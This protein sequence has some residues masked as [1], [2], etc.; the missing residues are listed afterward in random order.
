MKKTIL[1]VVVVLAVVA[2]V[3]VG[4]LVFYLD[5]IAKTAVEKAGTA[6]LGVPTTLSDIKL[7]I[8]GGTCELDGLQVD[9]PPGYETPYF[10]SLKQ[11]GVAVNLQSLRSD[12][13]EVPSFKLEGIQLYLEKKKGKANYNVLLENLKSVRGG[14]D[15]PAPAPPEGESGKKFVIKQIEIRD[16]NVQVELLPIGGAVSRTDV[17]IP[18]LVLTD[19][20]SESDKGATLS[21]VMGVV[22][23]AVLQAVVQKAGNLPGDLVADLSG[24]LGD[25]S[26]LPGDSM[27]IIG[28]VTT[29]AAEVVGEAAKEVGEVAEK[30]AQ[31][32][33]EAL[34]NVGNLLGGNKEPKPATQNPPAE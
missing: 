18:E 29:Q 33:G 11:G 8:L 3:A 28:E 17:H 34:K 25:L 15:E 14:K 2:V 10:L 16:V 22:V 26:S 27:K 24:S 9:N 21:Q 13:V 32:A 30:A 1:K 12:T 23:Q 19:F 4:V 31:G 6:A 20:G 5:A 7:G